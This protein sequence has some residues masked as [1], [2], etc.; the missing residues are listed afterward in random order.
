MRVTPRHTRTAA[1]VFALGA[2]A[3]VFAYMSPD[4]GVG[5]LEAALCMVASLALVLMFVA[6][7]PIKRLN[8]R[9][10]A[11]TTQ[12]AGADP[13]LPRRQAHR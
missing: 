8:R 12:Q 5:G 1:F 4:I 10:R 7:Y 6:W 2:P 9:V 11:R 3:P 13:V